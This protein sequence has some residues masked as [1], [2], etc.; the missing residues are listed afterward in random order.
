MQ[1]RRTPDL[2]VYLGELSKLFIRFVTL[3]NEVTNRLNVVCRKRN[4]ISA[5]CGWAL[6]EGVTNYW[7]GTL[8][9]CRSTFPLNEVIYG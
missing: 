2:P 7:T 3:F 9:G 8:F 6:G 4:L 5:E 1:I